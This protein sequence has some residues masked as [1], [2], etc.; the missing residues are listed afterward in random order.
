MK[1]VQKQKQAKKE[2]E[3]MRARIKELDRLL[4]PDKND[5]DNFEYPNNIN[6]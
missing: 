5:W 6:A 3:E 1:E 4:A 2:A